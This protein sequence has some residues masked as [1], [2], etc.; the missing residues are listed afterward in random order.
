MGGTFTLSD[1]SHGID[2]VAFGFDRVLEFADEIGLE[3]LTIFESGTSAR[4][5]RFPNVITKDVRIP[6]LRT[7]IFF[8][9]GRG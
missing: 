6:D 2:Q 5:P 4:D 7:H 1:D 9:Q 8:T 3:S